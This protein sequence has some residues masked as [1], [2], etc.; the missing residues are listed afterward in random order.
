MPTS[1]KAGHG[2]V[3]VRN[4]PHPMYV[5]QWL[6]AIASNRS[7]QVNEEFPVI[8]KK[9]RDE[10]V[11]GQEYLPF[12]RS[13][14]YTAMKVFLQLGL[15]IEMREERGKFVYKLVMLKF[16]SRFCNKH[17]VDPDIVIQ[18]LA[19]IARRIEKIRNVVD[20]AKELGNELLTLKNMI[21]DEAV[22]TIRVARKT[23][24]ANYVAMQTNVSLP[25]MQRLPLEQDVDHQ[26]PNLLAYIEKRNAKTASGSVDN[27]PN[28]KHITRHAWEN[29]AF[30]DVNKLSRVSAEIDVLLL[31]ADFDHWILVALEKNYRNHT[32]SSIRT[33]ATRY[34]SKAQPFYQNDCF[35]YS[36]MVLAMLKIIQ[37]HIC[38]IGK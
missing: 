24:N 13:G 9:M 20:S 22:E 14:F 6:V 25:K 18:M 16:M 30:P 36:K 26:I 32:T 27:H 29:M 11:M 15:T 5:S 8:S 35:G 28:A 31:L 34:M 12:R 21:M 17:S 2:F 4:V 37:V 33:L 38:R 3:E 23:L 1:Q 10:V 7:S 19:K